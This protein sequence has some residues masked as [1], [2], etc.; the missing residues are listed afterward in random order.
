MKD[1][2]GINEKSFKELFKERESLYIKNTNM[3]IDVCDKTP[4][5]VIKDI[6][7]SI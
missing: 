3:V 1:V 5:R 7:Q 6:K 4:Q 2:I